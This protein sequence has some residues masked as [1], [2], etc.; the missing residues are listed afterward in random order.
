MNPDKVWDVV[1]AQRRALVD[2]L[3]ALSDEEWRRPSLC[4]GWTVRDVVAHLAI[5]NDGLSGALPALLRAR[6]NIDR[7]VRD[8]ACHA[9]LRFPTSELIARVAAVVDTRRQPPFVGHR[10]VLIDWLVHPL[11]IMVPLGRAFPTPAPAAAF[12]IAADR[13]WSI[14]YP[15]HARKRF[16]GY[17]F[18]ASD[19]A[20]SAGS[21]AAVH[22]PMDAILLV[23]TG[24][25]AG[26]ARL[27]GEG[28][29]ALRA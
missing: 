24:R 20:W 25:S 6:G 28:V 3:P 17:A 29:A 23:L 15:F 26:S 21:G 11:D 12:A 18:A 14:G 7:A 2:L 1:N 22:G 5:Q 27:E 4:A 10:E 8:A 16:V 13:V 9:A 19:A